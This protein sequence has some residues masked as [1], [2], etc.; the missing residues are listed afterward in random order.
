MPNL[1][2]QDIR[3]ELYIANKT[4]AKA[5]SDIKYWESLIETMSH[6]CDYCAHF[7]KNACALAGGVTPPAHV[8]Q[9][10]CPEWVSDGIPF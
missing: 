7:S 8:L 2:P 3:M 6:G 1:T 10:G 9:S 4:L 5:Q